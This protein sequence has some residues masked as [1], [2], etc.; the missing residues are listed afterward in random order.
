[1]EDTDHIKKNWFD[2]L[3]NEAFIKLVTQQGIHIP[4]KQFL[5]LYTIDDIKKLDQK[6]TK[7]ILF[8][9]LFT[10]DA[11]EYPEPNIDVSYLSNDDISTYF[12]FW[13]YYK[14]YGAVEKISN[15]IKNKPLKIMFLFDSLVK[16]IVKPYP[17]NDDK[18]E[19]I[20]IDYDT[21]GDNFHVLVGEE[22]IEKD[23]F[24]LMKLNSDLSYNFIYDVLIALRN[25][26]EDEN[27]NSFEKLLYKLENE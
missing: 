21:F 22:R 1:M 23:V 16:H 2:K 14:I 12:F 4:T 11:H 24:E 8:K 7:E 6:N 3:I 27:N 20:Y 17:D 13:A 26:F 9:L 15:I 25:S 18:E 10:K 5:K 19:E